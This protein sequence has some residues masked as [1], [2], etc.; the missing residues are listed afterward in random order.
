[1]FAVG[2]GIVGVICSE[3]ILGEGARVAGARVAGGCGVLCIGAE[4]AG[5]PCADVLSEVGAG[6]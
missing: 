2:D 5:S 1:M 4:E 3:T 6:P